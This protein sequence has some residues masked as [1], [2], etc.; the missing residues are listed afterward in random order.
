MSSTQS[1]SAGSSSFMKKTSGI[2]ATF[3]IGVIILSFLLS[4]DIKGR[5]MKGHGDTVAKVEDRKITLREYQGALNRKLDFY[6]QM[7]GGQ[8]LTTDQ[9]HQMKLR[10]S[11]IQE[12]VNHQLQLHFAD[13]IGITTSQQEITKEIA[14]LPYFQNNGQFDIERYKAVLA[15]NAYSPADFEK[16]IDDENKFKKLQEFV[17]ASFISEKYITEMT[18][19]KNQKRNVSALSIDRSALTPYID[20]SDEEIKKFLATPE[21]LARAKDYF[22]QHKKAEFDQEEQVKASHILLTVAQDGSNEE[23]VKKKIEDIRKGLTP[24][25]FAQMAEKNSQDPSAKGKGGSLGWFGHGRMMKDFESAAFGMKPGEI[26]E[27]VKTQFG[28]HIIYVEDKKNAK[29]AQFADVEQVIAKKLIQKQKNAELD[30]LAKSIKEEAQKLLEGQKTKELEQ[31]AKKY[32]LV[33][34]NQKNIGRLDQNIGSISLG[35]EDI[36][37]IFADNATGKV[38]TAEEAAL[39]TL[40]RVNG[41]ET[42]Q[43]T[44]TV[45]NPA[46][47]RQTQ[48]QQLVKKQ[49]EEVLK[50]LNKNS[51][52]VINEYML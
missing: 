48:E 32:S 25:N 7:T 44:A 26:S 23:A 51:R 11:T 36:E 19:L 12:L 8:S 4:Y 52:I 50:Y 14:S 16:L 47:E 38:I 6:R 37:K 40:V 42:K 20:V 22:A 5:Y 28:Y 30:K 41:Q 24:K 34:E 10:E 39:V 27:P 21:S 33:F 46:Q 17:G 45:E 2:L 13:L 15:Q 35:D 43:G 29:E 31:L 1:S 18:N 9:I 3:F 49:H